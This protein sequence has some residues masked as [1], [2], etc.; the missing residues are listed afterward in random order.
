M[1]EEGWQQLEF[2]P[3][4]SSQADNE[5]GR[6]LAHD[7]CPTHIPRYMYTSSVSTLRVHSAAVLLL[8]VP[9]S[10]PPHAYLDMLCPVQS[11]PDDRASSE[12]PGGAVSLS[13]L[14]GLPITRQVSYFL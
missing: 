12:P 11:M 9:R 3:L 1:T 5:R 7:E 14:K 6:L 4:T 13:R 2:L 8:Y 10:L